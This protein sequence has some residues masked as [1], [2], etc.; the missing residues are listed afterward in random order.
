MCVFVCV[1]AWGRTF[2]N[3]AVVYTV[4]VDGVHACLF[5]HVPMF[6]LPLSAYTAK[7]VWEMIDAYESWVDIPLL[8]VAVYS[9]LI[10]SDNSQP[11]TDSDPLTGYFYRPHFILQ[12]TDINLH[13][14]LSAD[15]DL[16]YFNSSI[17]R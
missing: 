4:G 12:T 8:S 7:A 13:R 16:S 10:T 14:E 6:F 15:R 3:G 5:V 2:F 1:T 11:C 17:R 9:S